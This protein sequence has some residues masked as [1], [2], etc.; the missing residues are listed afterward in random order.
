MATP[1]QIS[2]IWAAAREVGFERP[3]VYDLVESVSGQRSVSELTQAQASR[4]IDHLVELGATAGRPSS[5]KPH[6]RKTAPNELLMI[7]TDQRRLIENLRERLGGKWLESPYF[8]GACGRVIGKH[9]PGT[10]GEATRVIEMLKA[11]LEHLRKKESGQ[12][13]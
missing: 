6:G 9:R 10:A 11:R 8:E 5:P 12:G 13:G 4:V 2:K 1:G 7:T 3:D